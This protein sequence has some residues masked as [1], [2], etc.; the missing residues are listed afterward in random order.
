MAGM[1]G[2]GAQI[3]CQQSFMALGEAKISL[4]MACLRKVILLIPLIFILPAFFDNKVFGVF[5]AEPVCDITAAVITTL[6]F[7]IRFPKIMKK[8]GS[9]GEPKKEQ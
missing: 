8:A 6:A 7:M 1:C 2:F 5:L 3:A 4:F 9:Q